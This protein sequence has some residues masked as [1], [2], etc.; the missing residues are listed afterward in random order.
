[1][2][3]GP[4]KSAFYCDV[5]INVAIRVHLPSYFSFLVFFDFFNFLSFLECCSL[6]RCCC[7]NIILCNEE[8]KEE[9]KGKDVKYE[10]EEETIT[11]GTTTVQFN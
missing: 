6:S 5:G 8:R 1:M 10:R 3:N 7:R 11:Q 4:V 2:S 9:R